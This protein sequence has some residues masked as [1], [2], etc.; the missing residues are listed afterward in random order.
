MALESLRRV[1]EASRIHEVAWIAANGE[2]AIQM[3]CDDRPDLVL[4]DLIMPGMNGVETTRRIMS[5]CPCAILVVT[6]TVSG[7]SGMV[8]E[9]M[10]AG[11][12]DAVDTPVLS[13]DA[14][15]GAQLLLNKIS[16]MGR[17]VNGRDNGRALASE[18][19][20]VPR[21]YDGGFPLLAIGASTGGPTALA[22]VLSEL[23]P[24]CRAAIVV[25][26]HVDERFAPDLADWLAQQIQLPVHIVRNG[27]RIAPGRVHVA[28]T[29][30]HLTMSREGVFRYTSEPLS[31]PYRP[32]VDVFFNMVA[33]VWQGDALGVLLTGMGRDGA[34]GLLA[35]R[36]RGF[37][38]IAQDEASCAVYGM[39][40]AAVQ[41]DAVDKVM[42]L[43]EIGAEV[44]R[45]LA[46]FD[47]DQQK[48]SSV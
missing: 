2:E 9:A 42:P 34:E 26:Q 24:P 21:K 15:Q 36:R 4:M 31:C 28:C 10:G 7:N 23:A 39:P 14:G 6:S 27:D 11:A 17:L 35:I 19:Q 43:R 13:G 37:F 8:F 30:D 20:A 41:L 44:A 33:K 47:G 16:V 40:K 48:V 45:R 18:Q 1:I 3:C 46:A 32:S 22:S 12:L 38:T 5:D 25:V 29:S